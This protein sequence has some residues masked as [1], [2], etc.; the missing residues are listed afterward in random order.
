MRFQSA[1]ND[2]K[3]RCAEEAVKVEKAREQRQKDVEVIEAKIEAKME[4]AQANVEAQ[5]EALIS[6]LRK[7]VKS[8]FKSSVVAYRITWSS[9]ILL[10][11]T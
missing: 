7:E 3:S 1:I 10:H 6:R 4:N 5:R 2:L 11:V 9:N 8:N